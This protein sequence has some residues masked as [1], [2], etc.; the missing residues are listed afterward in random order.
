MIAT[1]AAKTGAVRFPGSARVVL[2]LVAFLAAVGNPG[3]TAHAQGARVSSPARPTSS[4][5]ERR[6]TEAAAALAAGDEPDAVAGVAALVGL[7]PETGIGRVRPL[8]EALVRDRKS[9]PLVAAQAANFVAL[10]TADVG[11][12]GAAASLWRGLGLIETAAVCGPFEATGRAGIDQVNPP[13]QAKGGPAPGR[14]FAG[15]EREVAWREVVGP[16]INGALALDGLLRPDK[17]ASAYVLV[18]V[19]SDRAQTAVL[20]LG[21]PGPLKVWAGGSLV[22]RQEAVREARLDQDAVEISLPAGETAILIKTV[23]LSGAWRVYARLTDVAGRPLPGIAMKSAGRA[24]LLGAG[25][26]VTRPAPELGALLR[27]RAEAA[28]KHAADNRAAAAWLGYG[29]WLTLSRQSDREGKQ[30]EA[31]LER[32]ADLGRKDEP[33]RAIATDALLLL[34]QRAV[35]PND[36][37]AALDRALALAPDPARKAEALAGLGDLSRAQRREREALGRFREALAADPENLEAALALAAEEESAGVPAAALARLAALSPERQ[38]RDR[39]QLTR[40]RLLEAQGRRKEGEAIRTAVFARR[41][42]DLELGLSLARMARDRGDLPRAIALH[43]EGARRRPDLTF[44]ATEAA[45]MR[46]GQGDF[47]KAQEGFTALTV[48]LPDD[49]GVWEE[50]GRF[51]ARRDDLRGASAALRK[52]LALRP[53]N[54][55]LRRYLARIEGQLR[56]EDADTADELV[57]RHAEDGEALA[58]A[59]LQPVAGA[60]QVPG[61]TEVLLEKS[62]VRVHRNGL[63]ERYVQRVVAIRT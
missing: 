26:R 62:V 39:V 40:A 33:G 38:A 22:F 30:E 44:V 63:S 58:R 20:R 9:H 27:A 55:M 28:E 15:K 32:A 56:G 50:L 11:D 12:D 24:P 21:S 29:R 25:Q 59:G 5:A 48:R 45:R 36:R 23:V 18:Y 49:A 31:A 13:E 16:A 35:E 7:V 37:R 19:R 34:G 42:T 4:L 53:Q 2:V 46:E 8:F 1:D 10:W 43:D 17:D 51:L 52:A 41:R 61:G 3:R 6:F 60:P 14:R 57:R 47:A 54:P